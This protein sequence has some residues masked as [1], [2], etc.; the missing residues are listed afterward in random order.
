MTSEPRRA[1]DEDGVARLDYGS[2]NEPQNVEEGSR[3]AGDQPDDLYQE[4]WTQEDAAEENVRA[5]S[6]EQAARERTS[7]DDL[8]QWPQSWTWH[9]AGLVEASGISL[10]SVDSSKSSSDSSTPSSARPPY[11]R[12]LPP[13]GRSLDDLMVLDEIRPQDIPLPT[14]TQNPRKADKVNP[15][16]R[17]ATGGPMTKPKKSKKPQSRQIPRA[18]PVP[19]PELRAYRLNIEY[20]ATRLKTLHNVSTKGTRHM[21]GSRIVFY[22]HLESTSGGTPLPLRNEPWSAATLAP[23]FRHFHHVTTTIPDGCTHRLI[24]VEDL[25]LSLINLLGATFHIPPHVFEEHLDQS[26]Y[27]SVSK[28]QRSTSAW[29]TRSPIQGYCTYSVHKC[30]P[31]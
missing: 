6:S 12:Q 1:I 9:A 28:S 16:L 3:D 26:G 10:P 21:W 14:T 31:L 5:M 29:Q 7:L 23:S 25:N 20:L 24:L 11:T 4:T 2:G 17:W 8:E 30:N 22:D 27:T 18:P 15:F 19:A 13:P